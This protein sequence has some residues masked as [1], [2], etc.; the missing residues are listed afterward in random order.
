MNFYHWDDL[1]F[2]A[3]FPLESYIYFIKSETICNEL[4]TEN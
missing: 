1:F 2:N 4:H 3:N